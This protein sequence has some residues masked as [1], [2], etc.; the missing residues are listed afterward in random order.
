MPT[1]STCSGRRE[2]ST[3]EQGEDWSGHKPGQP[4][5]ARRER[6]RLERPVKEKRKALRLLIFQWRWWAEV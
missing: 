3:G 5:H 1:A 4:S 2:E 6:Q